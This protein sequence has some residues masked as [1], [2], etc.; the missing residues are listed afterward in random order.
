M[1]PQDSRL[2]K[3]SIVMKTMHKKES[4]NRPRSERCCK[5]DVARYFNMIFQIMRDTCGTTKIGPVRRNKGHCALTLKYRHQCIIPHGYENRGV[6][7]WARQSLE[8]APESEGTETV[9]TNGG[10][11]VDHAQ[12]EDLELCIGK[13]VGGSLASSHQC[14]GKV[15]LNRM[16]FT[17]VKDVRELLVTAKGSHTILLNSLMI[18]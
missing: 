8:F 13:I 5:F 17:L 7:Q 11:A 1:N 2:M 12:P 4:Q 14:T 9:S 6:M 16:E 10:A 18:S 15:H 3:L